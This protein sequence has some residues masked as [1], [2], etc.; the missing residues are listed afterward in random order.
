MLHAGVVKTDLDGTFA[1]PDAFVSGECVLADS[2]EDCLGSS[3]YRD[4][5]SYTDGRT[6][7]KPLSVAAC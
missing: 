7:W 4:C 1:Q 5:V 2:C 6:G 3:L